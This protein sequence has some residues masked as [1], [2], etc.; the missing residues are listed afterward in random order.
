MGDR[1]PHVPLAPSPAE[2]PAPA[3]AAGLARPTPPAEPRPRLW[4]GVVLVV[5]YWL[6]LT[7]PGRV[8]SGTMAP[9]MITYFGS[10]IVPVAFA[11]WWLFASRIRW[12][13]RL[14]VLLACAVIGAGAFLLFHPTLRTV[15]VAGLSLY[16]LPVVTTGWVVWLLITPF[17]SWPVRRAGLLVVLL[18][19]WGYFTAVRFEGVDGSFAAK[20][21]YRWMPTA[22]EK[23]LADISA[24]KLRGQASPGA[25]ATPALESGDWPGFRGPDR[26]GRLPG[27]RI[28]TDWDQHPP[29]Q[30]WRHRVGPGWS[31]FAVVGNRLYTQEQ[32][33]EDEVVVCYDADTGAEVWA[34][35][36]AA[37]FTEPIAGAGPRAT[38]T[39]HEGKVY[40][41]GGKGRLNCLDAATGSVKWSRDIV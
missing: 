10:M 37:R 41:L 12:T 14:L 24:G 34:H 30:V 5:L 25:A 27:V 9:F 33:G 11:G 13:E 36:D 6:L 4:P 21:Q 39:F 26:D 32:R 2:A 40:A 1:T 3:A 8:A 28:A 16:V 15:G 23:L 19:T 17:L 22:E 18:L 20:F 35:A 38:P 29:K 7:V 31:S